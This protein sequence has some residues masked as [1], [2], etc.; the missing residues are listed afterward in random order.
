MRVPGGV[1][2][3]GGGE[4]VRTRWFRTPPAVA[5]YVCGTCGFVEHWVD[6]PK[7]LEKVR[8]HYQPRNDS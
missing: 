2:G 3:Q 1:I 8:E 4:Y 5:R 6:L 7:D